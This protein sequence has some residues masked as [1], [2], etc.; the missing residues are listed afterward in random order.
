MLTTITVLIMGHLKQNVILSH[1]QMEHSGYS[2][3]LT[4]V[5]ILLIVF[6]IIL[7]VFNSKSSS[8]SNSSNDSVNFITWLNSLWG[9][10]H[11]PLQNSN[12]V[13]ACSPCRHRHMP[14]SEPEV[15]PN[16]NDRISI[17]CIS[18]SNTFSKSHSS[19]TLCPVVISG[20][21]TG[22]NMNE[23]IHAS[24]PTCTIYTLDSKRPNSE[25]EAFR[26]E[27]DFLLQ[28]TLGVA[29]DLTDMPIL[30]TSNSYIGAGNTYCVESKCPV[31]MVSNYNQNVIDT[32]PDL[33]MLVIP[34]SYPKLKSSLI[35][36]PET[37]PFPNFDQVARQEQEFFETDYLS[38]NDIEACDVEDRGQFNLLDNS[39]RSR[40]S[41]AD[42]DVDD[43]TTLSNNDAI[44][45]SG[46]NPNSSNNVQIKESAFGAKVSSTDDIINK[47]VLCEQEKGNNSKTVH[48]N[49]S[50]IRPTP[51][52][53]KSTI[54]QTAK[55]YA[56]E[57]F[58]RPFQSSDKK[59]DNDN[60]A[61]PGNNGIAVLKFVDI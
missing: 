10:K 54:L 19:D 15:S 42:C 18:A 48:D 25:K 5:G 3:I 36:K 46:L 20:N 47:G 52:A 11:K 43:D 7:V 50:K 28:N 34:E 38:S 40:L 30:N 2:F 13:N 4:I 23:D 24:V 9:I 6:G 35:G 60:I 53:N 1:H 21:S 12:K 29:P 61:Y 39:T 17:T 41:L 49:N 26:P 37:K 32:A 56:A 31:T 16:S 27:D 59:E 57:T 33:P 45:N 22:A 44:Q 58:S 8:D 55:R 14:I 51:S